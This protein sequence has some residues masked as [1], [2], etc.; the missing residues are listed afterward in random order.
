MT[1]TVVIEK[2]DSYDPAEVYQAVKRCVDL[3]GGMSRFVQPGKRVLLKP[4][5]LVGVP[6]EK[7]T[8]TH[9]EIVR[10][11]ASLAQ[12]AGGEVSV[13]DSPCLKPLKE[14]LT[15]S[16]YDPFM[17][18]LGLKAVPFEEV[19][20]INTGLDG[21]LG[22]IEVATAPL[23]AD[24]V[25]NLPKLKTHATMYL[26]VAVKN[27]FGCVAGKRKV[28]WHFKTDKNYEH[29]GMALV[30]IAKAVSPALTIVD[31]IM[32]MEGNGPYAGTPRRLGVI[33]AGT[34]CVAIDAVVCRMLSLRPDILYTHKAAKQIGWGVT[35]LKEIELK[36]VL[37]EEVRVSDFKL[38]RVIVRLLAAP[39]FTRRLLRNAFTARPR[40]D[41]KACKACWVCAEVCTTKA[42]SIKG[43]K[44][45]ID[46][47]KC[48]RCFCCQE[49]CPH[50]AMKVREGYLVWLLH[51]GSVLRES[52][53]MLPLA[54]TGK[55]A[56]TDTRLTE[57]GRA[58]KK[59]SKK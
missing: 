16:G 52:L 12:E 45:S 30:Q 9:P 2:C 28:E 7:V 24:V 49:I 36:G 29:F 56:R 55:R 5:L 26:T 48:I 54:G 6:P 32:A 13:G 3:L 53:S 19:R 23:E 37:L 27:L 41:R 22:H 51:Q 42:I 47:D 43:K 59:A 18:E 35:D 17:R 46:Y 4:N 31:A 1:T 20:R 33:V 58:K 39:L 50:G 10:A 25:I 38:A 34:D 8:V 14:N 57:E 11:V 21:L 15:K 40:V 44:V